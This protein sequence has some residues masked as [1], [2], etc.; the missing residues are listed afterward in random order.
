[1]NIYRV[2]ALWCIMG[3]FFAC[4]QNI[5]L[6]SNQLSAPPFV[7][8]LPMHPVAMD[9]MGAWDTPGENWQL[10]SRAHSDFQVEHHLETEPGTGVLVNL[11]TENDRDNLFSSWE[12]S[13]LEL[14]VEVLMPKGSNSG[15][16]FQGRYE[17]QLLDSWGRDSSRHADFAGIYQRWDP[18]RG[19]G[20]EGFEGYPPH[21]NASRA[22]GLWQKVHALFRAPVFNEAGEKVQP[23]K[24]EW[25]YHNGVLVHEDV[26]LS[27][28]TRAAAFEDE[29]AMGPLMIQGDH[30]PVAFRNLRYKKYGADSLSLG[31]L[32]Y[33]VY[34]YDGDTRPIL[35]S[36]SLLQEGSTDSFNVAKL[37]EQREHFA[38][39]LSGEFEAPVE[40]TYLFQ[41]LL[42]D[43]G[44]LYIDGEPVVKN[45]GELE[46]ERISG[47]IDLSP[48]THTITLVFF[49]VTWRAHA[50]I[51]YEGPGIELRPLASIDPNAGRERP[52]PLVVQPTDNPE[53]L[54]GFVNHKGKKRT[55]VLSVGD[56]SGIHYSYDLEEGALISCWKGPF[57]DVQ[58]MWVNRGHSQLL[59][60]MN[61]PIELAGGVSLA[62]LSEADALWPTF[63]PSTFK[64]KGYRL[65]NQQ[66]PIFEYNLGEITIEDQWFPVPATKGLK[67]TLTLQALSPQEG[68]RVRMAQASQID[69]LPNGLYRIEGT[70]Y[71][72]PGDLKPELKQ[73]GDQYVLLLPVLDESINE[74]ISYTLIW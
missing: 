10:A 2:L 4:S 46:F 26:E 37:S 69:P 11:P 63:I 47:T 35:D 13:D 21:I 24:F 48:G 34:A 5:P 20:A 57:A 52:E 25:V 74:S 41:T 65:D 56:T 18:E 62:Y 19:E 40:G 51:Y 30:G 60:P 72:D 12:H 17:I 59:Q 67:R 66:R 28:P 7:P 1:M 3:L 44:D 32:T 49:Q 64:A 36:L 9:S 22:P 43:G 71:L 27:G 70:F 31:P 14:E 42:D 16:Y 39:K 8:F 6:S 29:A 23:A 53:M 54:R 68:A 45:G 58:E 38:M 61:A 73:L 50:T 55:H 33:Q 15:I